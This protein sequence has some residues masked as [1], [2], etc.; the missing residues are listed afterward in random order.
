MIVHRLR[1]YNDFKTHSL[2]NKIELEKHEAFLEKVTPSE[3]RDFTVSGYS[4]TAGKQ[5][6]F[7]VDY[8]HSA[9]NRINWRERVFCPET[10]FNN[11]MRATFHI[12]DMEMECYPNSAIYITEKLT[13]IYSYFKKKFPNTVGSEYIGD[14]I[15]LGQYNEN[16]VR[17][18][19]LCSLTFPDQ[20]FD[21]LISLD[22]LE[23]IPDYLSAFKECARVLKKGKKIL[24][25]VPFIESSKT[26]SIR[27]IIQDGKVFHLLAPEF[28][29]NP[30]SK[31]GSLCFQ[32]FG[33][34]MLEQMRESGFSET[35]ALCFYSSEFGYLG[36]EQFLFVGVK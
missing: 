23:H 15:P 30:L 11:R 24:W 25:S 13:P 14:K 20:S 7:M 17:N 29:G 33:W 19:D 1:S 10:Y 35:Y 2:L 6:E 32:H 36:G 26:N 5:V 21:A 18:E 31:S 8:Q 12:F 3:K 27:A 28:H 34:E 4:Y 22:V 16:G 9:E